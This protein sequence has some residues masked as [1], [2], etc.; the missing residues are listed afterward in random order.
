MCI[1]RCS[2]NEFKGLFSAA[3]HV[4]IYIFWPCM[5]LGLRIFFCSVNEMSLSQRPFSLS[6]EQFTWSNKNPQRLQNTFVFTLA[7]LSELI[8]DSGS[9]QLDTC[10]TCGGLQKS[11]QIQVN[12]R[13]PFNNSGH[14]NCNST[15]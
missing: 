9:K 4:Q 10:L 2:C 13:F 8:M 5:P 15:K 1:Q 6:V 12:W 14:G 3:R 7:H 11:I